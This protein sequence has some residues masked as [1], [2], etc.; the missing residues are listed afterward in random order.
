[1]KLSKK[2]ITSIFILIGLAILAIAEFILHR[3]VIFMMDDNWYST[4]L[5]SGKPLN[6]ISDIFESQ[7]WHFFNWGGRVITHGLLQL[8]LMMGELFCNFLN[9]FMTFLLVQLMCIIAGNK[10]IFSFFTGFTLVIALNANIK[11]S[12]FWQSGAANYIYSTVWILLY[13]WVYL[14]HV[15]TP[16]KAPLSLIHLWFPLLGLITGW[17]NENMGP[18]SFVLSL[19]VI[20][21]THIIQKRKIPIWMITGSLFCL[22]GSALV[23]LAPGNFVRVSC[24]PEES[25]FQSLYNRLV[26]MLC[27]GTEYLFGSV[28]FLVLIILWY[29]IYLKERLQPFHWMLLIHAILSYGAMVLSPHYPDRATFGTMV[30]CIILIISILMD[31]FEKQQFLRKYIYLFMTSMWV[32][33]LFTILQEIYLLLPA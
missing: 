18:A 31:I 29:T 16:D 11:M 19:I 24:L 8:T 27:A 6:S 10:N 2:R 26:S 33:S 4:N 25:F 22:S 15:Q 9:L 13:L 1:M 20:G 21:Y 32:Y 23:I 14:R 3:E 12:M 5:A 7:H 30:V 17:S 28:L